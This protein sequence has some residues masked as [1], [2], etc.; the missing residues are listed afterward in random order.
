[1]EIIMRNGDGGTL[2]ISPGGGSEGIN[3]EI[4][5]S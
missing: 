3:R 4:I 5:R 2:F 1:M